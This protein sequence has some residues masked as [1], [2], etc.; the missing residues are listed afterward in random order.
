MGPGW[1]PGFQESGHGKSPGWDLGRS[2][3]GEE[4]RSDSRSTVTRET[5]GF[6]NE[7]ETENDRLKIGR[8]SCR[9]RV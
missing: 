9:E 6:R 1:Q 3:G 7:L 5:T 4:T 2:S 8:A